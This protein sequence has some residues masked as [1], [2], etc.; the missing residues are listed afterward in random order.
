M[1]SL[2][3]I[4]TSVLS[5]P[6][7]KFLIT[8]FS[9]IL[10]L[11]GK[12]NFT[13]LSRY[14]EITERSYRRQFQRSFNFIEGNAKLIEQAIPATARQIIAIDCSFIPKSGKATFGIEHFYNGS[15]GR[16]EKGLEIS[17]LAIVDVDAKQGYSLSVQQTPP[18]KSSPETN[19]IDSYLEHLQATYAYLPK[20]A[21]YVVGDGFYSK[22][23]WVNGV[24]DLHLDVISKLR[25]DADLRYVY[26]GEQKPRGRHRKYDGK[27]DLTDVSRMSLVRELEP[28][29]C[30][31]D[32]VVWSLSLKRKVRLAYLLD[33]R[34]PKRIGRVL[35]FSTDVHLDASAIFDFY[36]ARFQIEF[37]FRDAKQF[38]G[39]TDCQARD[40]TKLDFHFN[41]SLMALNLAKF[42]AIQLHKS[43]KPFVFSMA[44]VKRLALNRHLLD[45]F[46]SLLDLD[47]TLIKSHPNFPDLCSYGTIAF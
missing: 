21:R 19:R 37:I 38:T 8:L 9:T 46:I 20:L 5:K 14:S 32:V 45:R 4:L 24:T 12:V 39:L 47:V 36:T 31:Y 28:N 11:C 3:F 7:Q 26:T 42:E 34:N 2:N 33:S 27:V 13:N 25:C 41:A 6:Q 40:F 29:L 15:A 17:V 30:L 10:V 23:K 43:P 18:T 44:S 22:I 1:N 35:L 16:A